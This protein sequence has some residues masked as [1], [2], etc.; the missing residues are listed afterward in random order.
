MGHGRHPVLCHNLSLLC[1]LAHFRI[2]PFVPNK[3]NAG[4]SRSQA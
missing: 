3:R 4:F 1:R 2:D